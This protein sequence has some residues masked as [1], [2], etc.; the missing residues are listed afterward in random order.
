M[1]GVIGIV[2]KKEDCINDLKK[3]LYYLQHRAQS[4]CGLASFDEKKFKIITHKGK[5]LESFSDSELKS[6]KGFYGI[7]SVANDRQPVS[8]YSSLGEM[9]ICFDG[10]LINYLNLRDNFIRE[11]ASF[12]GFLNPGDVKNVD[13]ISRTL[14]KEPNFEKGIEK[15]IDKIEGDFSIVALIKNSVYAARGW[16]RKPLILG[17]NE[18][19]YSVSSESNSFLNISPPF[20]IVRDVKPG[21]VVRLDKEGIHVVREFNLQP[22]KFGTFEWIYTAY[23][24]SII[25]GKP[26]SEVRKNIGSFLAKKYPIKADLVSPVPNSG[27]WHAIGFA[28]ESKI[29]YEEIFVRYDYSDRSFT[30]GEQTE[31]DKVAK[32]KLIPITNSI[33]GKKIILVDDSIVRGTQTLNQ[34]DRLRELGVKEVHVMVA[35]PPL[36]CACKY[37]DTTKKDED[38][39]ARRL[40][41]EKIREKLNIDSLNYA[42]V[43]MLEKA[44]G[45]PK[46]KLC[47]TCWGY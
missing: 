16:G 33:K 32:M 43:S 5:V 39:I 34:V 18:K 4:Y 7:G 26:V 42:D 30:P 45:I 10:N 29:P 27:R 3:G 41:I 8:S 23:P 15:L 13:L 25:D 28:R 36:M 20:E 14:S 1:A 47:L 44:T 19:G 37:G 6:L 9:A 31:R 17:E 12:T 35:C 38:C 40:D 21:E 2:Y 22:I 24:T 46:E 11:G